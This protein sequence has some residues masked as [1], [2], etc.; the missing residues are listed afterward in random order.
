MTIRLGYHQP[1]FSHAASSAALFPAVVAQAKEA[2]A[3]GFDL[4]TVMD[5]FYQL[6]NFGKPDEPMLEAYTTL[7]ALAMA[8][9]RIALS[10]MVTG[11]TYR[12]PTLLAKSVTTLDMISGGR[13]VLGLGAG[14]YELEHRE[15]GFEFG[16]FTERFE[17][18]DEALQIVEP[19]LRG[20]RPTVKGRW[21]QCENAMNEPRFR[22]DLPIL[23]GGGGERKTF[24]LAA[25]H[26]SHLNIICS[27]SELPRKLAAV[28][29]RC[30][31]AGRDPDTL[32][33][34]YMCSVIL[35]E[36]GDRA[37]ELQRA[38]LA[39]RGIDLETLPDQQR[40]A[41]MDRQFVGAPDEVAAQLRARV[42]DH[43]VGGLTVNMV[44]NGHEPGAIALAGR[45][46]GPLVR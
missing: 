12:N 5:H 24:A 13:A 36:D 33:T 28:R 25:R 26:A 4:I 21:Y 27:P 2:E 17:R 10:A 18:L 15:L 37:R 35:D 42:L 14:W 22:D 30:A 46:L 40:A 45:A 34:T 11:N 31:E 16:T 38:W 23:L 19:M 44:V 41:V 43:G 29:A 8:T 1:Y 39:R 32:D 9:E 6:P 3:A 7:S 20:L